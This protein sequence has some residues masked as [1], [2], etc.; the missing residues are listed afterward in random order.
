MVTRVGAP[1]TAQP[2]RVGARGTVSGGL[3]PRP[4]RRDRR[5]RTAVAPRPPRRSAARPRAPRRVREPSRAGPAPGCA[6]VPP[7]RPRRPARG[8]GADRRPARRPP[9][10]RRGRRQEAQRPRPAPYAPAVGPAPHVPPALVPAHRHRPAARHH[11]I[12][13]SRCRREGDPMGQQRVMVR[14]RNSLC[15]SWSGRGGSVAG[16]VTRS[17][18]PA[19]EVV[20]LPPRRPDRPRSPDAAVVEPGRIRAGREPRRVDDCAGRRCQ[21]CSPADPDAP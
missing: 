6:A 9:G 14:T 21:H 5:G 2:T 11:R 18:F 13:S 19:R 7:G 17:G 12:R 4:P 15:R 8:P 3:P 20:R 10:R 1:G 16:R